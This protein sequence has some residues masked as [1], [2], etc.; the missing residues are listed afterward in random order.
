METLKIEQKILKW[1][2]SPETCVS[3]EKTYKNSCQN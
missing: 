1:F 2:H 3:T